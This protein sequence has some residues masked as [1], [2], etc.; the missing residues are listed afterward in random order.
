MKRRVTHDYR[1]AR[2]HCMSLLND[3]NSVS[4]IFK[5]KRIRRDK[6]VCVNNHISDPF[7]IRKQCVSE[8]NWMCREHYK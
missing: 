3:S 7:V 2:A 1:A 5:R 8:L 4:D 6:T